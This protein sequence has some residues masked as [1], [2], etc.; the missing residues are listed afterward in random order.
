MQNQTALPD[1]TQLIALSGGLY[2]DAFV[3]DNNSQVIFLS[4]W[5]RDGEMQHFFAALSLPITQGGYRDRLVTLPNG[6]TQLI[7]FD[8]VSDMK[9]LTTRLPK[10]T[11]VGEWVH[12]W[13]TLPELMKT[14]YDSQE[15]W[16]LSQY[17]LD[18]DK[19]WSTVKNVCHLPLLDEWKEALEGLL[20]H[21]VNALTSWGVFAYQITLE[22]DVVEPIIADAI[23]GHELVIESSMLLSQNSTLAEEGL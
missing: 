22:P 6:G 15:A 11:P 10:Y 21:C 23:K 5:A 14:P 20:G 4:L 1:T 3:L 12:T 2:I 16:V 8:R 19:L 9:K 7:N 18:W 13:L 17:A